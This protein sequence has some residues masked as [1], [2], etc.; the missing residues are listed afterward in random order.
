MGKRKILEDLLGGEV[1]A[2]GVEVSKVESV[3]QKAAA[4]ET[5]L[6]LD[7]WS[8]RKGQEVLEASEV[9]QKHLGVESQSSIAEKIGYSLLPKAEQ[10]KVE[11]ARLAAADFHAAAFEP[12]PKLAEACV[13]Q[14]R[15]EYMKQLLDTPDYKAL[16]SQTQLDDL[17]SEIATVSFAEKYAKLTKD[18]QERKEQ[19]AASGK[20]PTPEQDAAAC[21]MAAVRAASSAVRTAQ[22]EV[23]DMQE[24]SQAC[25]MGDGS[26]GGKLDPKRV[27]AMMAKVRDNQTLRNIFNNAGRFRRFARSCQR[28]KV[29]HGQDEIVGVTLDNDLSRILPEE[30]AKLSDDILSDDVM[31]RFV[32]RQT[33]CREIRGVE[34]VARGPVVFVVDESGSMSGEKIEAAKGLALTMAWLARKQRRW[35][36]L[37]AF[38]GGKE[39]RWIVLPPTGWDE[40]ALVEWLLAF[41][42]GGT[43]ADVPLVELPNRYWQ[44]MKAPA[45]KTDIIFV[46]DGYMDVPE[47]VVKNFNA[48]RADK[49]ARTTTVCIQ[50]DPGLISKVSDEVFQ[51]GS[52]ACEEE[53]VEKVLSI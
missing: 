44:E 38:S 6:E 12:E 40:E 45:G 8:L 21:E 17:S 43:V 49:K 1:P 3:K 42:G 19:D 11:A 47:S 33:V 13:D 35:C 10:D 51:V 34:P 20:K 14:L 46:T 9:L 39:G 53:A 48:W 23:A 31:R 15:H 28:R 5:A 32:E 41:L 36:G 27:A 24:A 37:L 22:T 30:L 29:L 16:H 26:G 2:V 4:S 18:E 52:L 7:K 25:G 50:G